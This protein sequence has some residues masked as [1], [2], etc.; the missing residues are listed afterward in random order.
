MSLG[1]ETGGTGQGSEAIQ[2]VF[3]R[4]FRVYGFPPG[5]GKHLSTEMD[6]L[7]FH[8]DRCISMRSSA[9]W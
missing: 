2:G 8:A 6:G 5:V 4:I 9:G 1:R 7:G 3:L